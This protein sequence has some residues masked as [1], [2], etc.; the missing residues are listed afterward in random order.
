M[1]YLLLDI[2]ADIYILL[3]FVSVNL[4]HKF[5]TDHVVII[6]A[7]KQC[8]AHKQFSGNAA[9]RPGVDSLVVRGSEQDLW[10]SLK[11]EEK[12]YSC[13]YKDKIRD[14]LLYSQ[15]LV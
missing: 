1:T 10:R 14:K 6:L 15:L 11:E 4:L 9:Q 7:R 5:T 13:G 12:T 3:C 2:M 8:L